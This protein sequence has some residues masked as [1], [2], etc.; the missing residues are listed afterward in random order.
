MELRCLGET[1][2]NGDQRF[3]QRRRQNSTTG[4]G[5]EQ[6][7][8]PHVQNP[9]WMGKLLSDWKTKSTPCKNL[10]ESRSVGI[11]SCE[12]NKKPLWW[13]GS[14][15]HQAFCGDSSTISDSWS[16][17]RETV[18]KSSQ[19]KTKRKLPTR[20]L[21]SVMTNISC[22]WAISQHCSKCSHLDTLHDIFMSLYQLA[23]V[24]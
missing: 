13:L 15:K 8:L 9:G 2:W 10:H 20:N 5:K 7:N 24:A 18:R 22:T 19:S 11:I 3:S 12:I 6:G 16:S 4:P 1:P 23:L 17:H 21:I 14:N